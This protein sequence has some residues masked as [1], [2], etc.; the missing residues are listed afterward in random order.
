MVENASEHLQSMQAAVIIE[1]QTYSL[2]L[3]RRAW[4]RCNKQG[5][6]HTVTQAQK[7]S[8]K[9]VGAVGQAS[10]GRQGANGKEQGLFRDKRADMKAFQTALIH[11]A[12]HFVYLS[13]TLHFF[14]NA[15]S[16]LRIKVKGEPQT[17]WQP[18]TIWS[19]PLRQLNSALLWDI[20]SI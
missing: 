9:A 15:Y 19:F 17:G 14:L 6:G 10:R 18:G 11:T 3:C 20:H 13:V 7:V 8:W 5:T 12:H 16:F 2:V 1:T 4:T